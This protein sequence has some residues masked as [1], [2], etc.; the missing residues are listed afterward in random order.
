MRKI[1]FIRFVISH[2]ARSL[3]RCFVW[4]STYTQR[5]QS[6]SNMKDLREFYFSHSHLMWHVC[7]THSVAFSCVAK[8]THIQCSSTRDVWGSEDYTAIFSLFARED[9]ASRANKHV[10]SSENSVIK[11]K[12]SDSLSFSFTL[13]PLLCFFPNFALARY[14]FS[15]KKRSF[16]VFPLPLL[17]RSVAA[18]LRRKTFSSLFVIFPFCLL[19]TLRCFINS[20]RLTFSHPLP[21]LPPLPAMFSRRRSTCLTFYRAESFSISL[22][23]FALNA[24]R[25]LFLRVEK[26]QNNFEFMIHGRRS[27]SNGEKMQNWGELFSSC[28]YANNLACVLVVIWHFP[29]PTSDTHPSCRERVTKTEKQQHYSSI[30][31]SMFTNVRLELSIEPY[32]P[33][34]IMNK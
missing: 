22:W 32:V 6:T 19:H 8:V 9:H 4:G 25:S 14:R 20:S 5:Q 16:S 34:D 7:S 27:G 29:K 21:V 17:L 11:I 24:L 13:L 33:S 26:K 1:W 15:Q 3:T 12:L 10:K 31:L 18:Y 28:Q 2:S 30:A 23:S